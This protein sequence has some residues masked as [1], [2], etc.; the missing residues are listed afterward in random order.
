MLQHRDAV[1]SDQ[2]TTL[3]A[4]VRPARVGDFRIVSTEVQLVVIRW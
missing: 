3:G 1:V 4:V 2:T